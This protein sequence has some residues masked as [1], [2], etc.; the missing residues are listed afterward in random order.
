MGIHIYS[1]T[2]TFFSRSLV[3]FLKCLVIFY[4]RN[5][6]LVFFSSSYFH[7]FALCS[8]C[9][10]LEMNRISFSLVCMKTN[11]M[12]IIMNDMSCS[13]ICGIGRRLRFII[14][15]VVGILMLCTYLMVSTRTYL[16]LD[17]VGWWIYKVGIFCF[18]CAYWNDNHYLIIEQEMKT[19]A[20]NWCYSTRKSY[21]N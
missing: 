8:T 9:I 19:K 6:Y 4:F 14:V 15:V 18:V 20:E 17:F 2:Q 3:T 5:V 21:D 11:T 1:V 10:H 13:C 16:F 7:L 12:K